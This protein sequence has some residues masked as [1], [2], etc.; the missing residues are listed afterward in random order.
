MRRG[1]GARAAACAQALGA[2]RVVY[3]D[4]N[5]GRLERAAALGAENV[6]VP[7]GADGLPAW[8]AK[9]GRFPVTVDASGGPRRAARGR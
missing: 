2:E 1:R 9:L 4:A 3:A 6:P 7:P 8:P 5:P